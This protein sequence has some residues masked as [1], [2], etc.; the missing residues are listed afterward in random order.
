MINEKMMSQHHPEKS[1]TESPMR[2][3][4][5]LTPQEAEELR[6]ERSILLYQ[7]YE[8]ISDVAHATKIMRKLF[9]RY[10]SDYAPEDRSKHIMYR[11][12]VGTSIS[13]KE[14]RTFIFD[15]NDARVEQ[16]LHDIMLCEDVAGIDSYMESI[17]GVVNGDM[18]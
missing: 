4:E 16:I 3:R 15:E 12:I 13:E 8:H 14:L 11:V 9:D 6:K 7:V 2:Y 18:Q 1:E 5:S 17:D 10:F